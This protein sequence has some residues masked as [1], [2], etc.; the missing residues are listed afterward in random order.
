MVTSPPVWHS[1]HDN[2]FSP[3]PNQHL[4][5]S[6]DSERSHHGNDQSLGHFKT[7]LDLLYGKQTTPN[8]AKDEPSDAMSTSCSE[9]KRSRQHKLSSFTSMNRV[10]SL[11]FEQL[12]SINCWRVGCC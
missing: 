10:L 12:S 3:E 7:A 11:R 8:K 2:L 9:C 1:H 6:R 5:R 4:K